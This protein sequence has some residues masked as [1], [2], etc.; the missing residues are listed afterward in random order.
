MV[1]LETILTY[2]TLVSIPVGVFYYIMTLRNTIKAREAS[3]YSTILNK[4]TEERYMKGLHEFRNSFNHTTYKDMMKAY[5][6]YEDGKNI[7]QVYFVLENLGGLVRGGFLGVSIV[8]YTSFGAITN[9]WEK[10][11]PIIDEWRE[12]IGNPHLWTEIEFLYGELIKFR[13]KYPEIR[14]RKLGD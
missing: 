8:A 10:T 6:S 14:D 13:N 5:P 7:Y 12:A 9:V 2:F 3:V 1:D 11:Q 4:L